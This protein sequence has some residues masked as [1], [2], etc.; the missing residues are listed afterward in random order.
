MGIPI[1]NLTYRIS[2]AV[3]ETVFALIFN[4]SLQKTKMSLNNYKQ[5]KFL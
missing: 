4:R 3:N 2:F 1:L 5:E